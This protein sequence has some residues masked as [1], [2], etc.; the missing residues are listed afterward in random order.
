MISWLYGNVLWKY[1]VEYL[2][3]IGSI[4]VT[5]CMP[6][7]QKEALFTRHHRYPPHSPIVYLLL[8]SVYLS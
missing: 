6:G 2:C 7:G 5:D 8:T 4:A 1:R 3:G